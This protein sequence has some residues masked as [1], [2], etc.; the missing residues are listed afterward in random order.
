MKSK[1]QTLGIPSK[2]TLIPLLKKFIFIL[3]KSTSNFKFSLLDNNGFSLIN[4]QSYFPISKE[5]KSQ[6]V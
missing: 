2:T 1:D 5:K 6:Q 4:D 3:K